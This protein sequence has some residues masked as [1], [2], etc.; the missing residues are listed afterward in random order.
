MRYKR[1]LHSTFDWDLPV[2]LRDALYRPAADACEILTL[3]VLGRWNGDWKITSESSVPR[4]RIP[5]MTKSLW[6]LLP[7]CVNISDVR[8]DPLRS[9]PFNKSEDHSVSFRCGVKQ[10]FDEPDAKELKQLNL[11]FGL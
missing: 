11:S 9:L 10:Q 4:W 3:G 1:A 6:N 7:R 8:E 5:R 2:P